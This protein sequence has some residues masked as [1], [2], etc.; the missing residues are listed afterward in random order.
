M[1]EKIEIAK[2]FAKIMFDAMIAMLSLIGMYGAI[3]FVLFSWFS[4]PIENSLLIGSG[5]TIL[6]VMLMALITGAY[7][8]AKLRI[9]MRKRQ[10][11]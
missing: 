2:E 7:H 9:D 6:V 10:A 8:T 3:V 1:S 4:F 11:T 5:V